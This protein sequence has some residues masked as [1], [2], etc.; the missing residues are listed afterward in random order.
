VN[1]TLSEF[2][3]EEAA[4]L[5]LIS[6]VPTAEDSDKLCLKFVDAAED[7]PSFTM[8]DWIASGPQTES[9]G[10]MGQLTETK[11]AVHFKITGKYV[12]DHDTPKTPKYAAVF[13]FDLDYE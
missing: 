3:V 1:V 13:K 7:S 2:N 12:G 10:A 8:D 5:A 4:N 9:N 11:P 6:T